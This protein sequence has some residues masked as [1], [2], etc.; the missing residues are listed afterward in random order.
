MFWTTHL[1]VR[2]PLTAGTPPVDRVLTDACTAAALRDGAYRGAC[3]D[4]ALHP[5]P[6]PTADGPTP[7]PDP[8][9]RTS[10][11]CQGNPIR[12]LN[13]TFASR[14]G[15]QVQHFPPR[16]RS[17]LCFERLLLSNRLTWWGRF[18]GPTHP[19]TTTALLERRNGRPF[20]TCRASARVIQRGL[21][22]PP[23]RNHSPG[24]RDPSSW[25]RVVIYT[26]SDAAHVRTLVVSP[27]AIDGICAVCPR[28]DVQ[29]VTSMPDSLPEQVRL[30]AS[31]DVFITKHG[32]ALTNAVHL[33][34]DAL[35]IEFGRVSWLRDCLHGCLS[36][37]CGFRLCMVEET[38]RQHDRPSVLTPW[39]VQECLRGFQGRLRVV[40][41]SRATVADA[42]R[43]QLQQLAMTDQTKKTAGDT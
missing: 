11:M 32:S 7:T 9:W 6:N 16:G 8:Q 15:L 4:N 39:V 30:F 27:S 1:A 38:G 29:V 2:S 17:G 21:G 41:N 25:K 3:T 18:P 33:P 36:N 31:T 24:L 28:C 37:L 35:V 13:L 26:R 34:A 43:E 42:Q 10:R 12:L 19:M 22:L 5:P 23:M 40:H 14:P 20:R